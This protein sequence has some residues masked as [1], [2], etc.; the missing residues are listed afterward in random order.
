MVVDSPLLGAGRHDP[1][2]AKPLARWVPAGRRMRSAAEVAVPA[3]R[4]EI[5][6]CGILRVRDRMRERRSSI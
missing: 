5:C 4:T 2:V 1:S 3:S 6:D